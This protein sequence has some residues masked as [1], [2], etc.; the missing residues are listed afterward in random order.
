MSTFLTEPVA[1]GTIFGSIGYFLLIMFGSAIIGC[2]CGALCSLLFTRIELKLYPSMELSIFFVL[3]YIPY[4][5][6]E[7]LNLSGITSLL[8]YGIVCSHYAFYSLSDTGQYLYV[9]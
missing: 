8:F 4:M 1:A 6:T 5:I 7:S 9:V 2:V 3:I